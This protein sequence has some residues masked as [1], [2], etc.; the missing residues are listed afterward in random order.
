MALVEGHSLQDCMQFAA[1]AGAIAVS[2]MG[3]VPSLPTHS[4]VLE[5][6]GGTWGHNA[7]L[8]VRGTSSD[9]S[10]DD[11]SRGGTSDVVP[12]DGTSS[13]TVFRVVGTSGNSSSSMEGT[14]SDTDDMFW[15]LED[16][17][18]SDSDTETCSTSDNQAASGICSSGSSS[19]SKKHI[20]PYKFASRLNSM[21][22]RRDLLADKQSPASGDNVLGWIA[23]Q[24]Q[25]KGLDLVYLNHPQHSDGVTTK[26]V[27]KSI[28]QKSSLQDNCAL[29]HSQ[30]D[31]FG[32]AEGISSGCSLCTSTIYL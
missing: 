2:R 24:G 22:A 5:L 27:C 8:L 13:D 6:L 28:F 17:T 32:R 15:S 4:E 29:L 19:S 10:L 21:K 23:R 20:C 7:V 3:A 25:V 26:Q 9:T 1:A 12:V 18:L 31:V 16:G 14:T 11:T 30:Y